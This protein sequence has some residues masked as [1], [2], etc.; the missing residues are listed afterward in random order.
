MVYFSKSLP[1]QFCGFVI[2]VKGA[3]G[4]DFLEHLKYTEK[5]AIQTGIVKPNWP[6]LRSQ[7]VPKNNSNYTCQTSNNYNKREAG[8]D[9]LNTFK[10][11]KKTAIYLYLG[12][13]L[14]SS[15]PK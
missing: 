5:T 3:A 9:L 13:K 14:E 8:G 11:T 6:L 12:F 10:V 1:I 7:Q 4:G 15:N 2:T